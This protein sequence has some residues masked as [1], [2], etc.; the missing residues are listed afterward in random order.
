MRNKENNFAIMRWMSPKEIFEN[1]ARSL[2]CIYEQVAPRINEI[3][4]AKM[5]SRNKSLLNRITIK[6]I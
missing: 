3:N 1:A 6:Y 4:R 2:K 5:K